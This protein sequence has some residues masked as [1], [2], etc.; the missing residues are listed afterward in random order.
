M[1]LPSTILKFAMTLLTIAVPILVSVTS[2]VHVQRL[3]YG[4][5]GGMYLALNGALLRR[6]RRG[7]RLIDR[8][9]V[10]LAGMATVGT[11]RWWVTVVDENGRTLMRVTDDE[12]DFL[13]CAWTSPVPPPPMERLR[14][15]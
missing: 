4:R 6:S 9:C 3:L 2:A 11:Q 7:S 8:R 1:L 15:L 13:L 14:E 5:L 10:T 12:L